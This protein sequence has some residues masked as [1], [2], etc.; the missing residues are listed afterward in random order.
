VKTGSQRGTLV[1]DPQFVNFQKDGSGDYHL[2][3][4]SPALG[5]GVELGAPSID[6]DGKPRPPEGG[7]DIG[8]YQQ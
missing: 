8:V 5:A 6:I 4:G 3:P 7:V 1:V 2:R